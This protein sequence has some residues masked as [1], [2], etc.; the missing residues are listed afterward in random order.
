LFPSSRGMGY[1]RK[2]LRKAPSGL[3]SL[4]YFI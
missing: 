4:R 1:I 2:N 3:T